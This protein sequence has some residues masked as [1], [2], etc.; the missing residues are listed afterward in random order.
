ME[1]ESYCPGCGVMGEGEPCAPDCERAAEMELKVP[2][3]YTLP[4]QFIEDTEVPTRWRVWAVI[5]GFFIGG[6]YCW[7][8]NEWIAKQVKAHKDTV[9][10]AVKELELL[11]IIKCRRGARSREI[12]PMIGANAY[13]WSAVTP[14]NKKND[15][16]QRL[17]IS[18][19]DFTSKRE[20]SA[21]AQIDVVKDI[22][23][24]KE[25]GFAPAKYP[26]AKDV[27]RL[28]KNYSPVLWDRN[29]TF[30]RSAQSLFEEKGMEE[31][32]EQMDWYKK[33]R[34]RDFCPQ[35]DDPAEWANKYAQ[36]DRFFDKVTT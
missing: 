33:N 30:L 18:Y 21:K 10:N 22:P 26:N 14:I 11:K 32:V 5:N 25:S 29:T 23:E 35:F 28:F 2:Y 7:A 6:Q 13:Q 1:D 20:L 12:Y 8:S 34:H 24:K 4:Q 3:T 15:R 27:F 9:S 31:L 36:I 19:S 16:P 17:S